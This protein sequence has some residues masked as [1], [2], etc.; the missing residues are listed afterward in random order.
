MK[1]P[2][3][4]A[5]ITGAS[6]GLGRAVAEA[7]VREGA[8]VLLCARTAAPLEQATAELRKLAAPGRKIIAK[9]CDVSV[10]EQVDELAAFAL[11]QFGRCDVLVNNAGVHGAIGPLEENSWEEWKRAVEVNLFG[12]VLPCRAVLAQM[13][14]QGRGKIINLSGG[15]A[16]GPRPF[17]TA[18]GAAKAAVVRFTET[19]AEEVKPWA[20]DINAVAPGKMKTRLLAE[21]RAA[22]PENSGEGP[23]AETL[24]LAADLVVFLASAESDGISGRLISAPWD[25]WRNLPAHRDELKGSPI[26]TLRRIVPKDVGQ[27]WGEPS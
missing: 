7:F 14:K 5:I 25:D 15:G 13:K 24:K 12:V 19:L 4:S 21:A 23:D 6:L 11:A 1:L 3:A 8:D 17:F 10:P 20:I 27:A 26:Y 2:G 18:Y 22:G 9:T 16:T